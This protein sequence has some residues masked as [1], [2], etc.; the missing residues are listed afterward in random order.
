MH[1]KQYTQEDIDECLKQLDSCK[2][3]EFVNLRNHLQMLKKQL[4]KNPPVRY[5]FLPLHSCFNNRERKYSLSWL[6]PIIKQLGISRLN[7][8]RNKLS[9]REIAEFISLHL[10]QLKSI[11][12]RLND[13]GDDGDLSESNEDW[14]Q[15]KSL[16]PPGRDP[17]K[18]WFVLFVKQYRQ[19]FEPQYS[20]LC[21]HPIR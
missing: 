18:K 1:P 12:L 2:P 16:L 6:S 20:W 7:L 17:G 11:D 8:S 21:P 14:Q 9:L 4:N 10:E 19:R 3:G 5:S 15:F 13:L